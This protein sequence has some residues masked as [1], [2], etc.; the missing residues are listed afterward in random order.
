MTEKELQTQ[1]NF[2]VSEL[3]VL[4]EDYTK[5]SKAKNLF[6]EMWQKADDRAERYGGLL[7]TIYDTI[8]AKVEK[9]DVIYQLV[10]DWYE[11]E[12]EK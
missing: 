1:I 7:S 10:D 9:Y 4:R 8:H 2:L 12:I 3:K 6:Y 5:L 11:S